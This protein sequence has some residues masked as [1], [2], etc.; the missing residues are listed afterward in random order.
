MFPCTS[1]GL[2][3]QNISKVKELEDYALT[4]GVCLYFDP[5]SCRCTIYKSRPDVCRIDEMFEAKYFKYFTKIAYYEANAEV[6][7]SLQEKA[8]MNIDFRINIG[9][10]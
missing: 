5:I 8:S 4:N 9:G 1:C 3:C 2:C 6:C 7:N 10:E